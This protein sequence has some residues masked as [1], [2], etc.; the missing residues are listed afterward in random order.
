MIISVSLYSIDYL[1]LITVLVFSLLMSVSLVGQESWTTDQYLAFKNND[2]SLPFEENINFLTI[3]AKGMPF[4]DNYE[5]RTETDEMEFERQQFQFRFQFNSRD[6]RKAYNKILSANKDRYSWLQAQYE[7]DLLEERYKSVLDLYFLQKEQELL[8]QE[9]ALLV[10]KKTVLKKILDNKNQ[11]DVED[12]MGNENE[13]FNLHLDSIELNLKLKEI[14]QKIFSSDRSL[15]K[16]DVNNFIK[17][18]SLKNKVTD[19]L[20]KN[21]KHPEQEM[22]I[23][24]RNLA[25]AEF[26]LENAEANKWLNFAQIEY[27]ADNKLSFQKELSL[28]TSITIPNKNNNRIKKNDATLELLERAYKANIKEDENEREI[29]LEKAKF[30]SL[31]NQYEEFRKLRGSQ[32]LDAIYRDFAAKNIVSPTVLIGIKRSIVKNEKKQI[33][34]EKDIYESYINL[35]THKAAFLSVPK[36]NYLSE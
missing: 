36:I 23:A 4:V 14:A 6:E 12:W 26:Q 24:E 25:D 33:N 35:L 34:I 10:D 2:I 16:L 29:Q 13:I 28:A 32:N 22:A 15:P 18:E 27:Q 21:T 31:L 17:I 1:K 8:S 11:I 9:F 19:L 3:K 7:L 30:L 5:F 20:E